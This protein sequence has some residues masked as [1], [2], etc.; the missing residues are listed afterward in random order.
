MQPI[1]TYTATKHGRIKVDQNGQIILKIPKYQAKNEVFLQKMLSQA[2]KFLEK[3]RQKPTKT[4]E[5]KKENSLLL[6]GEYVENQ[7]IKNEKIFFQEIL[8]Q[9]SLPLLQKYSQML[10]MNYSKLIF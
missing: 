3:T 8:L 1:I 4:I 7:N 2:E 6:F 5:V 10:G 9:K